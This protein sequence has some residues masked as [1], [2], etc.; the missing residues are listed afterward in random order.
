M[1]IDLNHSESGAGDMGLNV[2]VNRFLDQVNIKNRFLD[3]VIK[4]KLY[5][6]QINKINRFLE[7]L[8]I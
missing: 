4:I 5:L 3:H 7:Q 2:D 8:N 6:N 1:F